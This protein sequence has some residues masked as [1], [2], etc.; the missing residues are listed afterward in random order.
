MRSEVSRFSDDVPGGVDDRGIDEFFCWPFDVQIRDLGRVEPAQIEAETIPVGDGH[1]DAAPATVVGRH[2]GSRAVPEPGDDTGGLGGV[3]RRDI[4]ADQRVDERGFARLEGAGQRDA[5]RF[6]QPGTN[7]VEFVEDVRALAVGRL[8]TVGLN[9]SAQNCA[10]PI[11]GAH[12]RPRFARGLN[13][14]RLSVTWPRML[15]C[16]S[17]SR[18]LLSRSASSK[19]EAVTVACSDSF[20]DRVISFA[21]SR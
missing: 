5:D 20:N 3:R 10:D 18:T 2:P 21:I 13:F 9:G 6:A 8:T 16:R 11:A 19:C 14:S 15:R 17:S 12:A 1:V 7:A 4:V